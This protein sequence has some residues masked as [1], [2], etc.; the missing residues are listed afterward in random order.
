GDHSDLCFLAE[1]KARVRLCVATDVRNGRPLAFRTQTP[2]DVVAASFSNNVLG[3]ATAV[4]MSDP[5]RLP[6]VFLIEPPGNPRRLTKVNQQVD[7]RT[8]PNLAT[9]S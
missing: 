8:L 3:T 7:A 2:G 1:E 4:V 9:G 6:D 5:G